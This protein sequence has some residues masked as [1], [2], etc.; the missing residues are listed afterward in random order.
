MAIRKTKF[1]DLWLD[2]RW[3]PEFV[4]WLSKGP[5]STQAFCKICKKTFD[6]SN[7][8]RQAVVSHSKGKTHLN[9]MKTQETQPSLKTFFSTSTPKCS[10]PKNSESETR[11]EVMPST[12]RQNI[13]VSNL[14]SEVSSSKPNQ[15]SVTSFCIRDDTTR[16]EILWALKVVN[17]K[18]SLNTCSDIGDLFKLMFSD[19]TIASNF[20][21]GATKCKYLINHGL[22]PY[23]FH[24]MKNRISQSDAFVICFDESLNKVIQRGQ[25]DI[26]VKYFDINRSRVQ[27]EYFNSVFFLD[28]ATA[29]DLLD[30]FIKGIHL[31]QLKKVLQVFM[32]GPNVN[33]SFLKKLGERIKEDDPNGKLL[34]NGGVCGLHVINGAVK[35]GLQAVKWDVDSYLRDVYYIFHDSPAR[36]AQFISLTGKTLF[37]L[38]HCTTRWLENVPSIDRVLTIFDDIK[39][40]ID[41]QKLL[42]TKPLKNIAT[43]TKDGFLKC[44]LAFFKAI[45]QECEPFL[46]KF[47]TSDPVAPFLYAD[48][49]SLLQ[50]LMERFV[51]SS[52]CLL[53]TSRCV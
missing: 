46:I 24:E 2:S 10:E 42:H 18:I 23:F 20:K 1:S 28:R 51:K 22:S 5:E 36:C 25:M 35:T 4:G 39:K 50:N 37:P 33:L 32:D 40:Y 48:L 7:M 16:A 47:H 8:G 45:S 30:N 43:Q 26:F 12:S 52:N 21:M 14:P 6:L 15:Q 44:K 27:S 41:N 9:L 3:N 31:L 38:K 19:S 49:Q 13:E 53:Y 17:S 29:Q 34:I 11:D